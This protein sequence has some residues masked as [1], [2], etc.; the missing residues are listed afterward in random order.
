MNKK[1][2]S[3]LIILLMIPAALA[4]VT[5]TSDQQEYE[6]GDRVELV[7]NYTNT[8]K[9]NVTTKFIHLEVQKFGITAIAQTRDQRKSLM[10]EQIESGIHTFSLPVFSPPGQY[11]IIGY[12]EHDDGS[13]TEEVTIEITAKESMLFKIVRWAFIILFILI[14]L[15]IL[16]KIVRFVKRKSKDK[17]H[18]NSEPKEEHK[19][20]VR[21]KPKEKDEMTKKTETSLSKTSDEKIQKQ[22]KKEEIS[23]AKEYLAKPK[24]EE[25]KKETPKGIEK[26][27]KEPEANVNAAAESDD[28][29]PAPNE[30]EKQGKYNNEL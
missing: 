10:P 23:K 19:G 28:D 4:T 21:Q 27:T 13:L 26:K 6:P 7:L 18:R 14:L 5:L 12:V 17:P 1:I 9:F 20:M 30:E 15:I 22:K 25:V 2:T 11:D 3:L 16:T 29:M 8:G 24:P